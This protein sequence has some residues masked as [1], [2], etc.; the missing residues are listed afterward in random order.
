MKEMT[1]STT[2]LT[3]EKIAGIL[4]DHRRWLEGS[5]SGIRANLRNADLRGAD[6][7][8]ANL[9]RADLGRADLTGANLVNADLGHADLTGANLVNANLIGADLMGANLGVANLRGANLR[10]ADLRGADLGRA[11]LTGANLMYANLRGADLGRAD[12]TG[13]N[14]EVANLTKTKLTDQTIIDTGETWLVYRTEVVP[15]LLIA[16]GERST[17]AIAAWGQHTWTTCPMQVAFNINDLDQAPL[18]LRQRI[19]Q[20]VRFYDAE[21]LAKPEVGENAP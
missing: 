11:D 3:Q 12:L 15:Q 4:A 2:S 13:A 6:L 18:S 8:G 1:M 17:A 10:G 21:L 7:R 19:H 9:G 20:F 14:L 16:A 5:S